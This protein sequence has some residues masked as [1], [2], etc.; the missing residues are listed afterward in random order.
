MYYNTQTHTFNHPHSEVARETNSSFA[1]GELVVGDYRLY[2]YAPEPE[3]DAATHRI[4]ASTTITQ[5]T[6]QPWLRGWDVIALTPEEVQTNLERG[7]EAAWERIKTE[8]DRRKHLGVKVGS[9]WY[10]SDHDSRT[11]QLGLVMAG[12]ALP[13][14]L[15]WKTLS[16]DGLHAPVFV[17][18]T[19][20][21]AGQIFQSTMLSDAAIFA[22]AEAHRAAMLSSADPGS[23]NPDG[24][25]P[26]AF[27]D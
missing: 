25:W 12:A 27:G 18:M 4:E 5:R 7:R 26:E 15:M 11:Q 6:G 19:P 9:H 22:A 3:Y 20:V 8:R 21:L 13:P 24:G 10:H 1:V 16:G 23:Y 17:E 14:G 2:E